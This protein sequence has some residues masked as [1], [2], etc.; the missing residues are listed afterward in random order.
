LPARR[1]AR[2]LLISGGSGIT[3]VMSMLR[4]L[5]DENDRRPVT[6]LHY[7]RTRHDQLYAAEL[8][9]LAATHGNVSVLTV[10]TRT[11]AGDLKGR[12]SHAHLTAAGF[13]AE[14]ETFV[15]GPTALIEAVE[16]VWSKRAIKRPLHVEHFAPPAPEIVTE[17]PTGTIRFA[18]SGIEV[19]NNGEPLLVQAEAAGLKPNCGCRMGICHTCV[20]QMHSGSVRQVRTGEI[21]TV[22]DEIIQICINAPVGDVEIEL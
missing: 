18:K 17:R 6:F 11:A 8:R 9:E 20:V 7:A 3:P 19:K 15:C 12:F 4:T 1:P 14:C 21:K 22:T 16:G 5:C 13:D 2:L 10:Y